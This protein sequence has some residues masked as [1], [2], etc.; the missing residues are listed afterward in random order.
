MHISIT[1]TAGNCCLRVLKRPEND[2]KLL[3]ELDPNVLNPHSFLF[4]SS[5]THLCFLFFRFP[6]FCPILLCANSP[7]LL[8]YQSHF[9]IYLP[10]PLKDTHICACVHI[11]ELHSLTC[12]MQI[13]WGL[14]DRQMRPIPG[15]WRWHTRNR[16]H[17]TSVYR[18]TPSAPLL[19]LDTL[20]THTHWET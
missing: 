14:T 17:A 19:Y 11:H 6:F 10:K 7:S 20:H 3:V 1:H 15:E 18:P 9:L 16:A 5:L 12:E 8:H 13:S 4:Y 2:S